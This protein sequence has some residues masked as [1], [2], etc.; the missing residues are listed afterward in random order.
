M[1]PWSALR[2]SVEVTAWWAALFA[3]WLVLISTVDPLELLVGAAVTLPAALA[4]RAGRR[5]VHDE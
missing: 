1:R 3:L 5:A 4:A 2:A